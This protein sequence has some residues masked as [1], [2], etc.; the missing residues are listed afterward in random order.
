MRS[1]KIAVL[2][3][4]AVCAGIV[5]TCSGC[6]ERREDSGE[7]RIELRS[8]V[9]EPR[10]DN[11]AYDQVRLVLR[12]HDASVAQDIYSQGILRWQEHLELLNKGGWTDDVHV[13]YP[14]ETREIRSRPATISGGAP[15]QFGTS[16]LWVEPG[17]VGTA[18]FF[19]KPVQGVITSE[20]W[21]REIRIT[22]ECSSATVRVVI[23]DKEHLI[24]K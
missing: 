9:F 2:F 12:I 6:D 16:L 7:F 23:G 21:T 22:I 1:M 3:T 13:V 4:L 19:S 8:C 14:G 15:D 20:D 10:P 24:Q 5:A 11:P 17:L 18:P